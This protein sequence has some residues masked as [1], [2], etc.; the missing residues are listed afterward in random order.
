MWTQIRL[1]IQDQSV[2][3]GS[4]LLVREAQTFQQEAVQTTFVVL[5]L[6]GLNMEA[7]RGH[8]EL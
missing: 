1:L 5:A 6:L 3:S 4:T 8:F 2:R 7:D